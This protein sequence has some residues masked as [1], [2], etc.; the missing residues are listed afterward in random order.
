MILSK[1]IQNFPDFRGVEKLAPR[2]LIG[3]Y[4]VEGVKE[5]KAPIFR[6]IY[7]SADRQIY[8]NSDFKASDVTDFFDILYAGIKRELGGDAFRGCDLEGGITFSKNT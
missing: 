2:G 7:C 4:T 3:G 6:E 1:K 5:E 8:S